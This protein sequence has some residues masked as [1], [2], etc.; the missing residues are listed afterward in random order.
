[1]PILL[2]SK[3]A[4][5]KKVAWICSRGHKYFASVNSRTSKGNGCPYCSGHRV[6]KGFNDLASSD[7]NLAS[8]WDKDKNGELTPEMVSKGSNKKIWWRCENGHSWDATVNSRKSINDCPICR[9]KGKNK[10]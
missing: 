7:P 3:N 6:L 9:K 8:Q 4:C 1:M 2:S 10:L 5:N